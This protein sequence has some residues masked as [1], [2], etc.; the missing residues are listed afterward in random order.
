MAARAAAV[1]VGLVL[2]SAGA[3]SAAAV[4]APLPPTASTAPGAAPAGA[5]T[6]VK[7][8][9]RCTPPTTGGNPQGSEPAGMKVLQDAY[10][11]DA[12]SALRWL[13]VQDAASQ[14]RTVMQAGPA[15]ADFMSM[16]F[17]NPGRKV[18]FAVRN[19]LHDRAIRRC[20]KQMGVTNFLAI[21]IRRWSD[22]DVSAAQGRMI[23][24][25]RPLFDARLFETGGG[26]GDGFWITVFE[27]ATEDEYAQIEAAAK[28]TGVAYVITRRAGT[29]PVDVLTTMAPPSTPTPVPVPAVNASRA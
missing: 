4:P 24:A 9:A 13:R 8:F 29:Q 28:A 19:H 6:G 20:A 2:A 23:A 22:A 7:R 16:A 17:D 12:R 21:E 15:R 5:P 1:A 3:A 27:P 26:Q 14:L 11:L 18:R 25:V 10:G